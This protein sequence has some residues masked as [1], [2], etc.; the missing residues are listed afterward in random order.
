MP[1]Q[2]IKDGRLVEWIGKTAIFLRGSVCS[3]CDFAADL[4]AADQQLN[5]SSGSQSRRE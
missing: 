5:C 3:D 1:L 4:I 2:L